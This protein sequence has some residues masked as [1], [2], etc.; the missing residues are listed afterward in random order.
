MK[1]LSCRDRSGAQQ[2]AWSERIRRLVWSTSLSSLRSSGFDRYK[3]LTE[4]YFQKAILV[5]HVLLFLLEI[6]IGLRQC[7]CQ[8]AVL[9]QWHVRSIRW[10]KLQEGADLYD[11]S[12]AMSLRIGANAADT[13]ADAYHFETRKEIQG[14][15]SQGV[16]ITSECVQ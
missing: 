11:L 10:L 8:K 4:T 14:V 6:Q 16:G 12:Q 5:I 3:T 7:L 13:P 2:R 1:H 9:V 15:Y